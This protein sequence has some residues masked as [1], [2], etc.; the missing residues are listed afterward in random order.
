VLEAIAPGRID[1]GVGRAPGSD[2]RTALA[3]NPNAAQAADAFPA[4]VRDLHAW[5]SGFELPAN[6]PFRTVYAQPAGP[7]APELWML[8]SSDYG[9]QVA[10]YFGLPYCY[11]YFFN[12]GQGAQEAIDIYHQNFRP[13]DLLAAPHSAITIWAL[14]AENQEA[15]EH[16][17]L[18]RA[19]QGVMRDRGRFIAMPSPEE[20]AAF[21][22]SEMERAKLLRRKEAALIGTAPEVAARITALAKTMGVAEIVITSGAYDPMARR[23]SYLLLAREF[24]LDDGKLAAAS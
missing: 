3:L 20:A 24:A 2:G 6:H 5:V 23:N 22:M 19:I 11:A 1:L 21:E 18:P 8:G 10:A 9:A 16:A 14:A 17:Y 15:A 13:S 7:H 12:D 4:Q